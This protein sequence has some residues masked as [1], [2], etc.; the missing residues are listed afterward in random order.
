[1]YGSLPLIYYKS[2]NHFILVFDP[3]E[4]RSTIEQQLKVW[5]S[6]VTNNNKIAEKITIIANNKSSNN[7]NGFEH[8]NATEE[9]VDQE[10]KKFNTENQQTLQHKF[11]CID[12][13]KNND[14]NALKTLNV[15]NIKYNIFFLFVGYI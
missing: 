14:E 5:F 1:M 10:I 3:A 8:A 7:T 6:N 11:F 9:I 4:N 15:R 13:L 2:A 12:G